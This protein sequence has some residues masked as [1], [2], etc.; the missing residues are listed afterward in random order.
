MKSV[1]NRLVV[2]SMML[3]A[4]G[5]AAAQEGASADAVQAGALAEMP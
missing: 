1:I 2:V 5:S 4:M 3:V